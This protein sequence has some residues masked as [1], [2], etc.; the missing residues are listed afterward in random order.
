VRALAA[1]L[2]LSAGC[3]RYRDA[4]PV[5]L[6]AGAHAAVALSDTGSRLLASAV[7]PRAARL[8]GRL[9]SAE[10]S[11]VT[12]AVSSI[13]RAP[14]QEERWP[15]ESVRVPMSAVQR[16]EVRRLDRKRSA[17][18]AGVA[19]LGL[20]ATRAVIDANSGGGGGRSGGGQVGQ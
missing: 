12:L 10:P 6:A 3:Y 5:E 20:V 8:E 7:G 16:L 1:L 14:H 13:V 17:I 15:Q 9:L 11:G 18:F 4:R 2:L 19:V